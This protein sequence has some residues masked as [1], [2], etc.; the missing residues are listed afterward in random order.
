[1]ERCDGVAMNVVFPFSFSV[2]SDV[3]SEVSRLRAAPKHDRK[4][5][6]PH[7]LLDNTLSSAI[8]H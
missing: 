7:L 2:L 3:D 4:L 8:A 6:G 5:R 1:L